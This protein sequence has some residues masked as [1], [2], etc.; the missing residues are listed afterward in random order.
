MFRKSSLHPQVDEY[1]PQDIPSCNVYQIIKIFIS[2]KVFKFKT[3]GKK[4]KTQ[5]IG[6]PY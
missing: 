1:N 4:W 5:M 3:K 6:W 2:Q